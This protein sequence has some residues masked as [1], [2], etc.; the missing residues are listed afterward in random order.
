VN[1]TNSN[2]RQADREF[3]NVNCEKC[4]V[5]TLNGLGFTAVAVVPPS[6]EQASPPQENSFISI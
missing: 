1:Q 6:N 2:V 4:H 5:S 3:L